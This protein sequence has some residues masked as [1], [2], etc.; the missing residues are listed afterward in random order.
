MV[1][2]CDFDRGYI[3]GVDMGTTSIK[4][5]VVDV[6]KMSVVHEC[7]KSIE[8]SYIIHNDVLSEQRVQHMVAQLD[9]CVSSIPLAV[10]CEVSSDI[11]KSIY[12]ITW[13]V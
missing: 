9:Q 4:T 13:V 7:W 3:L 8:D 2:V 12:T 5:V 6:A 1:T 10:A 11:T